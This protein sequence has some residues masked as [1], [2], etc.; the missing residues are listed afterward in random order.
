MTCMKK[1]LSLLAASFALLGVGCLSTTPEEPMPPQD[2]TPGVN[3]ENCAASGGTVDGNACACPE[4]FAEDP[5]G[6]CLD[7]G[8]RPGGE[9]RQ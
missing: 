5:A 8:G 4:G 3:E 7:A 9:M 1:K 2:A 6:F